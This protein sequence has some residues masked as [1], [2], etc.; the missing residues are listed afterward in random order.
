MLTFAMSGSSRVLLFR[1][2]C[3]VLS[4]AHVEG[5]DNG[6]G[7]APLLAWSTWNRFAN[8][9]NESLVMSIG[10]A[11]V[12]TGLAAA[13]FDQVNIDAGAWLH[14]RDANGN[15]QANPA[16]FP[17][18]MAA[19]ATKLRALGLKLGLYT[20][21][22]V[23][24][25]GPGPGCKLRGSHDSDLAAALHPVPLTHTPTLQPEDTGLKTRLSSLNSGHLI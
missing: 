11:L 20:D 25:C 12:S 3:A 18:G 1:L 5:L 23:G 2:A 21:L 17:S 14:E 13:G 22:G 19:V 15:L 4:V 8:N 10:E 6:V 24:S 9:I 7:L 16:L